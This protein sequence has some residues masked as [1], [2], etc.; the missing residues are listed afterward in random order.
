MPDGTEPISKDIFAI[1]YF[2]W[3]FGIKAQ[4]KYVSF[5]AKQIGLTA[6]Q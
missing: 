3:S 5:Y 2:G 6:I 1:Y 4:R